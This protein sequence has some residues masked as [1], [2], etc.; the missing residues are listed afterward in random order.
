M[1]RQDLSDEQGTD[2]AVTYQPAA[3]PLGGFFTAAP[4]VE[5]GP[6]GTGRAGGSPAAPAAQ[7]LP[8]APRART[9]PAADGGGGGDGSR[10]V[11][12]STRRLPPP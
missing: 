3:I 12:R 9:A 7:G 10:N 2:D 6:P 8:A 4:P 11:R 5:Q 1:F